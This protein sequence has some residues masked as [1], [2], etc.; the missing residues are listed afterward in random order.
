MKN[1]EHGGLQC[2]CG[3][4][5]LRPFS[6]EYHVCQACRTLVSHQGLSETET[7]VRDDAN[8]YYGQDYWLGHQTA[9]LG[10]PSIEQRAIDD[11]AGRC[12][13]WLHHLLTYRLPPGRALDVGCSHGAFVGL[14]KAAGFDAVGLELSPWVCDFA[15]K[16]FDVPMLVG[17]LEDQNLEPGSFSAIILNDLIEHVPDPIRT[18]ET[19]ARLLADD[20]VLVIQT[21]KYP[22]ETH[23]ALVSRDAPFL[24]MMSAELSREHLHLFSDHSMG[25][26]LDRRGIAHH[27]RLAPAFVYDMYVVASKSPLTEHSAAQISSSLGSSSSGRMV[28]AWLA[29]WRR[30]VS[31][32]SKYEQGRHQY[33]ELRRT[34]HAELERLNGEQERWHGEYTRLQAAAQAELTR[35]N[36]VVTQLI[37]NVDYHARRADRL[38]TMRSDLEERLNRTREELED[39]TARTARLLKMRD[40]AARCAK[41]V[42]FHSLLKRVMRRLIAR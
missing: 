41:W 5:D 13:Y 32:E 14:M 42:P 39:L 28:D 12:V 25:M 31:F 3:N 6:P 40:A 2:W 23:E 24:E 35:Q 38:E 37:G 30:A 4:A 1:P 26:L 8:D 27:A 21:P 11:L 36:D 29:N 7:R 19:C 22:V 16:T 15:R 33:E 10:L 20:G 9:E 17:A 34:A 18:I